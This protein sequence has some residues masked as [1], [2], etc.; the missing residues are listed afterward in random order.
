MPGHRPFR[1]LRVQLILIPCAARV[2]ASVV[3]LR[4]SSMCWPS[5]AVPA[6]TLRSSLLHP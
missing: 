3:R 4:R 6:C 1:A 5:C 2:D